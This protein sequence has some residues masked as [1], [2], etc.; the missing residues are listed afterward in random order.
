MNWST[1]EPTGDDLK[2]W[3]LIRVRSGEFFTVK[4]YSE[5]NDD[6]CADGYDEYAGIY[7]ILEGDATHWLK[8]EEP[9]GVIYENFPFIKNQAC[10][11][12]NC[13]GKFYQP[14]IHDP[15]CECHGAIQAWRCGRL[16]I[17]NK[18]GWK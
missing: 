16:L 5:Y 9:T 8:I 3:H 10:P 1:I 2:C 15:N 4:S 17:C 7:S 18:C 12:L 6:W 13:D 11:N 14:E